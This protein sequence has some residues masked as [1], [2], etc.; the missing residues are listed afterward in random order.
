MKNVETLLRTHKKFKRRYTRS[1]QRGQSNV[2]TQRDTH[3]HSHTERLT[4]SHVFFFVFFA[5][6]CSLINK[7]RNTLCTMLNVIKIH[8]KKSIYFYC[9]MQQH[10]S[11]KYLTDTTRHT[12]VG[13]A[14][15]TVLSTL[16]FVP[17]SRLTP[18]VFDAALHRKGKRC[19]N[20]CHKIQMYLIECKR[21]SERFVLNTQSNS[22][23][24]ASLAP[25]PS[26]FPHLFL[27]HV[28]PI[29]F[30]HCA[31]SK[32]RTLRLFTT[33]GSSILRYNLRAE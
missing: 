26:I 10:E 19:E 28:T 15:C 23:V 24:T 31:K 27:T 20:I 32:S 3:T 17:S 2:H 14:C 16:Q 4:L 9:T 18:L 6:L 8:K 30:G 11:I 5:A 29:F 12:T 33:R 25:F 1:A 13:I 21:C 22:S 7:K